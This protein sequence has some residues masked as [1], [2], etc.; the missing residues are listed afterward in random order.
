MP[1]NGHCPWRGVFAYR[2]MSHHGSTIKSHGIPPFPSQGRTGGRDRLF[3]LGLGVFGVVIIFSLLMADL[4]R[5]SSLVSSG[6]GGKSSPRVSGDIFPFRESE[7]GERRESMTLTEVI[8][9]DAQGDGEGASERVSVVRPAS[10]SALALGSD[11]VQA[12]PTFFTVAGAG[13]RASHRDDD[14]LVL[15]GERNQPR[16]PDAPGA[17]GPLG[18]ASS[19]DVELSIPIFYSLKESQFANLPP[20]QQQAVVSLQNEYINYHHDW[21]EASAGDISQWNDRMREFHLE[22]VRRVG[23]TAADALTR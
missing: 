10:E 15:G 9:D 3:L 21:T 6:G 14:L 19:K 17:S 1:Q 12:T 4:Q 5:E 7:A 18:D 16:V 2:N 23:A 11:R 8:H 22:L 20:E 13:A